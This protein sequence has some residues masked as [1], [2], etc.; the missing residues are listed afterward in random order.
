MSSTP[1][2]QSIL[3]RN[4]VFEHREKIA[5][6]AQRYGFKNLALFGS[7]A[8]GDATDNSDID[9]LVDYVDD[10]V[11]Y[12][13]GIAGFKVSLDD[14]LEEDIGVVARID[15]KDNRKEYILNSQTIKVI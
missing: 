10:Y 7:V 1:T 12:D 3:L 2:Q 15:V 6:L 4:K 9:M 14:L 13:W 8:R 11:Y 5:E